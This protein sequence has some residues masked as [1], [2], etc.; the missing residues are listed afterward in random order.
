MELLT[1]TFLLKSILLLI[2]IRK[3]THLEGE[4]NSPSETTKFAIIDF[5]AA[6]ILRG[7]PRDF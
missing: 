6:V 2:R 1:Q 7:T 4:M 3:E 5:K